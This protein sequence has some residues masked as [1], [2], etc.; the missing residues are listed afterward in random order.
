MTAYTRMV[1]K[2]FSGVFVLACLSAD[3]GEFVRVCLV[4]SL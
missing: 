2:C 4:L 3:S 1:S